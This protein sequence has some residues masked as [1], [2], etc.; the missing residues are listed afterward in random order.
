MDKRR[1]IL[2]AGKG[3]STNILYN[4]L[5]DDYE[6][7]AVILEEPVPRKEFIKKRIKKLGVVT[8]AGQVLFQ[9]TIA[10][11]LNFT[12]TKRKHEIL[13]HY[14]LDKTQLP[15]EKVIRL[16]SINDT[17]CIVLLKKIAPEIVIVNGTRI[18]SKEILNS[19]PVKFINIH[20]GIT[21]KYR[22]VHGAYWAIVNN[23]MDNCGVTVHQ[24]DQGIDTGNIIY[25]GKIKVT[26]KDNFAT[27]PFLQLAEGIIYL[28]KALIDI[29]ENNL[30]FKKNNLES[31]IW[32]HPTL[33]QYLYNRIVYHKK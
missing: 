19:I 26:G 6:I 33:W 7:E 25:Q 11:Y 1:L 12:S 4:S 10:Q 23:D 30:T 18:I 32:H 5:K 31:K 9:F 14:G 27:Y 2:L 15:P 21:P 13:R 16:K 17:E 3:V 24:V 29:F 8:V 22:N 20:A 28:K